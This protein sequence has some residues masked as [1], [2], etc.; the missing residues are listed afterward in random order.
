MNRHALTQAIGWALVF[1][2]TWFAWAWLSLGFLP[3]GALAVALAGD[4]SRRRRS[5][6]RRLGLP[7]PPNGHRAAAYLSAA[8]L[9]TLLVGFSPDWL[10]LGTLGIALVAK[11]RAA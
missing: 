6:Q 5:A 3:V 2:A 11:L 10:V 1:I 7:H 4:A 8:L 9:V